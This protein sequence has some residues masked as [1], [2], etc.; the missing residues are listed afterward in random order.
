MGMTLGEDK[1][2]LR[3]VKAKTQGFYLAYYEHFAVTVW[4]SILREVVS[5]RLSCLGDGRLAWSVL[6]GLVSP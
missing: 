6:Y 1:K 2:N 3:D 5:H 4:C